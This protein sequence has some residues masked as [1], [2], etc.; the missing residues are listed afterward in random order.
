MCDTQ[1]SAR[2]DS[3]TEVGPEEEEEDVLWTTSSEFFR[4]IEAEK[5][6]LARG[7]S[8]PTAEEVYY[9]YFSQSCRSN[10]LSRITR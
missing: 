10:L 7:R 9:E 1:D 8:I 4:I 3:A 6:K 2:R 5:R